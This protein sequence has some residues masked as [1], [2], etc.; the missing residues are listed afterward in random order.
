MFK[1]T[2]TRNRTLWLD[3]V[4]VL[5]AFMV[6]FIHAPKPIEG[7]NSNIIY[8]LYN[9]IMLPCV[10][11]FF[12]IS[13]YLL[14]PTKDS[15]F[16][17][18]KKRMRRIAYPLLFWSI[19]NILLKS[20]DSLGN[21]LKDLFYIPFCQQANGHYWFLYSLISIYLILPVISTWLKQAQ[22]KEIRFILYIWLLASALPFLNILLPD[23]FNGDGNYYNF[24]YYNAGFIGYFILGFYLKNFSHKKE[25]I[26]SF[27]LMTIVSGIHI[28]LIYLNKLG[29]IELPPMNPYLCMD[30]ILQSLFIFLFI[31]K[32]GTKLY[33]VR[34]IFYFLSPLTFGIYLAHGLIHKYITFP[35]IYDTLQL[36]PI[37]AVPISA[38]IT[39]ATGTFIVYI[40]SKLP[41]SQFLIG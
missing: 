4:R 24:L 10:P 23:V 38:I 28:I 14:L 31:R 6:V 18:L 12:I 13:G 32:Y 19:I 34:N 20:H 3:I 1:Y 37:F 17:F 16:I 36:S 9:Y 11:L 15:L 5:A 33:Q 21:L 39:F 29:H 40:I 35:L 26:I 30:V 41:K 2:P 27:L 7:M 8:A 25:I 22:Q